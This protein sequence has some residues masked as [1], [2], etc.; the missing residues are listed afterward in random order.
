[1]IRLHGTRAATLGRAL[2]LTL[3]TLFA[4]LLL[5]PK[6]GSAATA[7]SDRPMKVWAR[8]GVHSIGPVTD[9]ARCPAREGL[10]LVFQTFVQGTGH[11]THV[12]EYSFVGDHCTYLDPATGGLTYSSGNWVLTA[13]NGDQVSAPYMDSGTAAPPD[14]SVDIVTVASHRIVGGTGRFEGATGAFECTIKLVITD[15]ATFTADLFG[16]CRGVIS[17]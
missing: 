17:Y 8:T 1:M 5:P 6:V 4:V 7:G 11:A 13:A 16:S 10:V 3:V 14:P 15:P 12:G 2:R 9:P